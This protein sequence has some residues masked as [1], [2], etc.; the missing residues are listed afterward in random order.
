MMNDATPAAAAEAELLRRA[1][2]GEEA[3][4]GELVKANY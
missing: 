1:R 3:A 2:A 4:Y